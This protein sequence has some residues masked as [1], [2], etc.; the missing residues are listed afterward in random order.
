[1]AAIATGAFP[2]RL[3]SLH[4]PLRA[5]NATMSRCRLA[6]ANFVGALGIKSLKD[7]NRVL[8]SSRANSSNALSLS[9]SKALYCCA[10]PKGTDAKQQKTPNSTGEVE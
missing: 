8:Q 3:G 10:H 6:A 9:C 5:Q 4:R 1:V 7:F 2:L